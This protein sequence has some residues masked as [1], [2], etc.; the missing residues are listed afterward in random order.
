MTIKEI[1]ELTGRARR[2]IQDWLTNCEPGE[3]CQGILAKTARAEKEGKAADFTLDETIAILKAGKM[4]ENLIAILK[5]NAGKDSRLPDFQNEKLDIKEIISETMK[6]MIPIFQTM[7]QEN[8][9]IILNQFRQPNQKLIEKPKDKAAY[10]GEH[11]ANQ[12]R[13]K[14]ERKEEA[15]KTELYLF[16]IK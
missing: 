6:G 7:I 4:G 3:I 1:A 8:N 16:E 9:K 11:I 10:I 2:T 13:A 15:A 12:I 5:E 14:Q